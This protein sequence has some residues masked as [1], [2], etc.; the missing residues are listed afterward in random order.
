MHQF[1]RMW[2]VIRKSPPKNGLRQQNPNGLV[3][4]EPWHRLN[5][6]KLTQPQP[7]SH[8]LIL[9]RPCLPSMAVKSLS[10]DAASITRKR[11]GYSTSTERRP[12]NA[13]K[14]TILRQRP[15]KARLA[16]GQQSG[17]LTTANARTCKNNLAHSCF[18]ST[19][20]L[21]NTLQL[22]TKWVGV[23]IGKLKRVSSNN[24]CIVGLVW[25]LV[26]PKNCPQK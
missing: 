11:K 18:G 24:I 1:P 2:S 3:C 16:Q 6:D 9:Q 14:Q 15:Q 5:C 13:K 22:L 12:L 17:R 19:D 7:R 23:K 21:C 26:I 20:P 8:G 25:P 10:E 4:F